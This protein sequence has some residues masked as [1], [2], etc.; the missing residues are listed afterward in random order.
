[1]RGVLHRDI[2]PANAI[3]AAEGRAKLLD[4]G[5]AR[6]VSKTPTE[7]PAEAPPRERPCDGDRRTGSVT[8]V[9]G[10]RLVRGRTVSGQDSTIPMSSAVDRDAKVDSIGAGR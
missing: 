7:H 8:H 6:V 10:A 5:L 2:K 3:L 4:F 9:V 1:R